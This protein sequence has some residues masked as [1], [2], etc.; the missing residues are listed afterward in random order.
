MASNNS[1]TSHATPNSGATRLSRAEIAVVQF[2]NALV[3]RQDVNLATFIKNVHD[4][5]QDIMNFDRVIQELK[6]E[7]DAKVGTKDEEIR[8]LKRELDTERARAARTSTRHR[9]ALA[10][11]NE[12]SV[13]YRDLKKENTSIKDTLN[14]HENTIERLQDQVSLEQANTEAAREKGQALQISSVAD[15]DRIR[16]LEIDLCE[17]KAARE[18]LQAAAAPLFLRLRGEIDIASHV[19]EQ[20]VD[21]QPKNA[22]QTPQENHH[23]QVQA[24]EEDQNAL[25]RARASAEAYARQIA[26]EDLEFI[27]EAARLDAV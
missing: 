9:H 4:S 6:K 14:K 1:I 16:Q 25:G 26:D 23:H 15:Q 2:Q 3:Q 19:S 24:M 10:E 11:L 22:N 7:T 8:Q 21:S 17:V 12:K 5:Q 20:E 13:A 18:A 27:I